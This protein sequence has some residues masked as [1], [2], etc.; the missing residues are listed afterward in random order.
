MKLDKVISWLKELSL[1]ELDDNIG[2]YRFNENTP[3]FL[4]GMLTGR[5][6]LDLGSYERLKWH[7]KFVN[8]IL[9]NRMVV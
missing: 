9:Q 8:N 4:S 3:V 7:L 2:T 5:H 1:M 6:A